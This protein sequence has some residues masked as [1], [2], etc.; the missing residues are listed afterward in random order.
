MSRIGQTSS[1]QSLF[2]RCS[3]EHC[4][5]KL[6]IIFGVDK[7]KPRFNVE[8]DEYEQSAIVTDVCTGV[9][10]LKSQGGLLCV[11]HPMAFL[12]GNSEAKL[13]MVNSKTFLFFDEIS[14]ARLNWRYELE[15][16]AVEETGRTALADFHNRQH[17]HVMT[18]PKSSTVTV[19]FT[20]HCLH[21]L[22]PLRKLLIVLSTLKLFYC[23][24]KYHQRFLPLGIPSL[25]NSGV[26][27]PPSLAMLTNVTR[28]RLRTF[29]KDLS[30]RH[31]LEII[32]ELTR[33]IILVV[34]NE[35]F[36]DCLPTSFQDIFG[37]TQFYYVKS[38]N[39]PFVGIV[40]NSSG[41]GFGQ[42]H[43]LIN[44][45]SDFEDLESYMAEEIRNPK[46]QK[47]DHVYQVLLGN[48]FTG[49]QCVAE[50]YQKEDDDSV[51]INFLNTLEPRKKAVILARAVFVST[52]Y[53]QIYKG[54]L[55]PVMENYPF[56]CQQGN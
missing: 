6:F 49:Y 26:P 28:L 30:R 25:M 38:I 19:A 22:P 14:P 2:M 45:M 10:V 48:D 7:N 36:N 34:K 53:L 44:G 4:Q 3:G 31:F 50:Y 11:D 39:I 9:V 43:Q 55:I 47:S 12:S 37:R 21:N 29:C 27:M 40:Y 46:D 13:G 35:R 32:D 42:M 56:R 17:C 5:R 20:N 41:V 54:E 51:C 18:V 16:P 33:E 24:Y 1:S 15:N 52:L 23:V 8:V